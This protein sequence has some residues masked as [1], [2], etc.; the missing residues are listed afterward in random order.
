MKEFN[1]AYVGDKTAGKHMD[2][3]LH[4]WARF[5]NP[6]TIDAVA[7]DIQTKKL[8]Q[9][10]VKKYPDYKI[11]MDVKEKADAAIDEY[12]NIEIIQH[13]TG[14]V[15]MNILDIIHE[16]AN[17][18]EFERQ[19]T[20]ALKANQDLNLVE[21]MEANGYA[22]NRIDVKV[23]PADVE[24]DRRDFNDL[25]TNPDARNKYAEVP[26][27]IADVYKWLRKSMNYM[28]LLTRNNPKF[29]EVV[30]MK[31]KIIASFK[32]ANR[33]VDNVEIFAHALQTGMIKT[34]NNNVLVWNYMDGADAITVNLLAGK[35]FDKE[36]YLYHVFAK[37]NELSADRL[38]EYSVKATRKIEN[39]DVIDYS[40]I[41][42][43]VEKMLADD[44]LGDDFNIDT[45]NQAAN[46]QGV[47]KNYV[48]TDR[49]EDKGNPYK[50]LKRFY[51]LLNNSL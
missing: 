21:F 51:N 3:N 49:D 41:Q 32:E 9:D 18:A 14:A 7:L 13:L 45:I 35:K 2:E 33:Y 40:D 17:K 47:A 10:E 27:A 31:N 42:T 16:P 8:H 4:D 12:G 38:K 37:F 39:A 29:K 22:I 23:E 48:V 36:Y 34:K 46:D 44:K 6:Y 28:D 24:L 43:H 25:A 26:V 19:L 50:V 11:L 20:T 5:Q 15:R 30:D 1:E